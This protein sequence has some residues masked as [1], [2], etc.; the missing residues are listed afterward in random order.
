MA[1]TTS[2]LTTGNLILSVSLI[3][4]PQSLNSEVINHLWPYKQLVYYTLVHLQAL[5]TSWYSTQLVN[6]RRH[7]CSPWTSSHFTLSS[8]RATDH[9]IESIISLPLCIVT[10]IFYVSCLQKNDILLRTQSQAIHMN[11]MRK[12]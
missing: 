5:W 4:N 2:N 12:I 3:W 7:R 6:S 8:N 10:N 11:N 1:F 9:I